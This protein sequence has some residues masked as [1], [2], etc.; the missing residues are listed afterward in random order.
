MK[1]LGKRYNYTKQAIKEGTITEEMEK[2]YSARARTLNA[3][4]T[5]LEKAFPRADVLEDVQRAPKL[6]ELKT[7]TGELDI[8]KFSSAYSD[9]YKY[10]NRESTKVTGYRRQMKLS[11]ETFNSKLD[12]PVINEENIFDLYDFL[13]DYRQKF[14]VQKIPNSDQVIDVYAESIR[15]NIDPESL[16]RD[17]EFWESHFDEMQDLEPEDNG[18]MVNSAFYKDLIE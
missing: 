9:V 6:S 10:L 14:N 13:K 4:I 11:I 8:S 3:R 1:W 12:K 2:E 17:M 7:E 15:L 18:E 16:L 5:R